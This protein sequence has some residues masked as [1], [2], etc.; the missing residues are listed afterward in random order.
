MKRRLVKNVVVEFRQRRGRKLALGGTTRT[1][2]LGSMKAL[3]SSK[4]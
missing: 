4:M 1:Q 2:P 3:A